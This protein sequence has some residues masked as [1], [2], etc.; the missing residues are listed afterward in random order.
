[1]TPGEFI[2]VFDTVAEAPGGIE[3][4]R[5][6]VLQLAVR[7]KLVPQ[8]EGEEPAAVLLEQIARERAQLVKEKVLGRQES[9]KPIKLTDP[10]FLIP[11][12]WEWIPATYPAYSVSDLGKKIRTKE[13][14][15][16]GKFPVVDQGK[17][18][19]R[20]YCNNDQKVIKVESP[21]ILFGDHTREIKLID[22]DFVVGADGVKILRPICILEQFYFL[23]LK[24]LPLTDRGYG[25]HFKLLKA[26]FIP[27]PPFAEQHR[28]VA[29]VDELMG[30]IDRLEAAR[31][32]REAVRTAGRDSALSALR[33]AA[34]SE[35]VGAGWTRIAERMDDLFTAPADLTPLRE[36]VLQLAVRGRLVPQDADDEPA[37][38]LLER[39]AE[40][41][42]RIIKSKR[43]LKQKNREQLS[44]DDDISTRLPQGWCRTHAANI[45]SVIRGVTYQKAQA[46][47]TLT[48]T[49][50]ALLRAHN[51]QWRVELGRLVYVPR[52]L[53]KENQFLHQ[54]D[55][56]FCIASGSS[57]L[58]G[59]SALIEED[60]DA[61]FGAFTAVL[62]PHNPAMSRFLA[63]YCAS[64]DGRTLL[65]GYGQGIGIKNLKT[66]AL[67]ALPISVP[68]LAEQHRIVA[69]VDELM[70]LIDRLEQH[71]VAKEET[72]GDFA[73]AISFLDNKYGWLNNGRS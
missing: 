6:L 69:K 55:L 16:T 5:E 22:F 25:R 54:G 48:D 35:E 62:R 44:H 9:L 2:E 28:I 63:L 37:A 42:V 30:L 52:N 41:N 21:L 11:K 66:T 13:V 29:Q 58:V 49:S 71:L 67:A 23:A 12:S 40:E 59:K 57:S 50:I 27:L 72:Q 15:E 7:G 43:I 24:W 1:M 38:V 14:L 34:T 26:G 4:L 32:S 45:G 18:K 53:V 46:S 68:P 3:R 8:D 39:I 65:V 73:I 31:R 61:T 56:L 20:G 64:P 60:L 10:P 19:I 51:I 36:S 47:E 70:E 17:I 33:N